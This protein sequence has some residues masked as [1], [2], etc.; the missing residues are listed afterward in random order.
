MSKRPQE[1][2]NIS[3]PWITAEESKEKVES[4]VTNKEVLHGEDKY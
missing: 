3:Q 2:R 4:E 1:I